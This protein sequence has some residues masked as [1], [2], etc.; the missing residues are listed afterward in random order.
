MFDK[1]LSD[2]PDCTVV[3]TDRFLFHVLSGCVFVYDGKIS[4]IQLWSVSFCLCTWDVHISVSASEQV[5]ATKQK[6]TPLNYNCSY[7]AE[8]CQCFCKC[9]IYTP[10][11]RTAGGGFNSVKKKIPIFNFIYKVFINV[12][13]LE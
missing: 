8:S 4:E 10:Y 1:M 6:Y 11:M 12:T 9:D 5:P 7:L 13:V 2:K 3:Y